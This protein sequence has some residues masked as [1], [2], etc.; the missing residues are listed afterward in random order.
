MKG[1]TL[2]QLL[3]EVFGAKFRPRKEWA[4]ALGVTPVAISQWVNSERTLPAPDHLE[5]I[6]SA[7][8]Q[9]DRYPQ[10]LRDA[11]ENALDRP[12]AEVVEAPRVSMGQTLRHYLLQ[13]R[14][15]AA[16]KLVHTL[17]PEEQLEVLVDLGERVRQRLV[18][19]EVMGPPLPFPRLR[20]VD[21]ERL[22]EIK[23]GV[24]D[25]RQTLLMGE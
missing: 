15:E 18:Q 5:A 10:E 6:A 13:T 24:I 11:F 2:K 25:S 4:E 1:P 22:D 20:G 21:R 3:K 16:L 12:I 19:P 7:L 23:Q 9:D 17:P 14:G 8:A